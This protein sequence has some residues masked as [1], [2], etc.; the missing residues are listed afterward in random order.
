M[1]N[2]TEVKVEEYEEMVGNLNYT[3]GVET[4]QN[5]TPFQEPTPNK[6]ISFLAPQDRPTLWTTNASLAGNQAESIPEVYIMDRPKKTKT[7]TEVAHV[8]RLGHHFQGQGHQAALVGCTGMQAYMD[9]HL[10]HW[11]YDA[12]PVTIAGLGGGILWRPPAYS[13]SFCCRKWHRDLS[14]TAQTIA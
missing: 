5:V 7:G 10:S 12:H 6:N 4:G 11:V 13:L 1:I 2:E 9:V 3:T 8:T 14:L